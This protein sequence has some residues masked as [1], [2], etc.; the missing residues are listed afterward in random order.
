MRNPPMTIIIYGKGGVGKSTFSTHLSVCLS[1]MG[2]SVLLIGCDPKTDTSSRLISREKVRTLIDLIDMGLGGSACVSDL[3]VKTPSGV[4]VMETGGP[5]PGIGCSGR[6]VMSLCQI[7][8]RE[9]ASSLEY[10][11]IVFDVL[12][13]LVCG[14]FVAPLRF[15]VA[16]NLYI[17][18][19]EEVASLYAVNNIAKVINQPYNG[20]IAPGGIV[21]NIRRKSA[22]TE[23]LEDFARRIN[24]GILSYI[25][26]DPLIQEAEAN[27]MTAIE[28]APDSAVS[29]KYFD[30]AGRMIRQF[31]EPPHGKPTPLSASDFW[32]F[33][34]EHRKK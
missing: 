1:K 18:S 3:I 10:D 9:S 14:G 34:R 21:F 2:K 17:V 27:E 16:N 15:A 24:M 20:N 19:S 11:A 25:G 23:M 4:D 13:D 32:A 30:I 29:R 12:G 33:V 6:G 28:Y 8:S 31:G 7:L 5:E 26:Y 22:K